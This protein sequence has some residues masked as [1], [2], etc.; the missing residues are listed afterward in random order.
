MKK[1]FKTLFILT[2]LLYA[3]CNFAQDCPEGINLIPQYGDVKKCPQQLQ[4][5]KEFIAETEKQFNNKKAASEYY[6][7]KGWEYFYKDDLDTAMKRFNKAWLLNN[8]NASVYWGFGNILGKKKEYEKSV[9]YLEKSIALDSNNDK[10]YYCIAISYGQIFE[11]KKDEKYL[12]LIIENFKKAVKINPNNGNYYAQI[13]NAYAYYPKKDSVKLY[14]RKTDK[15]DPN[16][17]NPQI[18]KFAEKK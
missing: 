3:S 10:V 17:I 11:A 5:D 4:F 9:F 13:A 8:Q 14:I 18:R 1:I 6:A 16:L 7:S 2:T 15:I 12:N